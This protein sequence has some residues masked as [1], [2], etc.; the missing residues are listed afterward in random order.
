M[1]LIFILMNTSLSHAQ[2]YTT[3]LTVQFYNIILNANQMI[4][5]NYT[6][7]PYS[8]ILCYANNTPSAST[9]TWPYKGVTQKGQLP[10]SLVT[11]GKYQ[12]NFADS[13]GVIT[14]KSNQS[15]QLVVSCVYAL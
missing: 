13:S 11:N 8:I 6:F 3:A 7:G 2:A 9:M 12:G 1:L 15:A 10:I 14:I 4:S 5:S